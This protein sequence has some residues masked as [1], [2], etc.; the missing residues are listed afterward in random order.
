MGSVSLKVGDGTARFHRAT[1]CS[2]AVNILMI[3]SVITTNLFALY[4]FTA[5]PKHPHHS[6]LHHNAHKNISLISEQVSLILREIDLSQKKLAQMEKELLGYESIDL[7]RP[8]IASE[9]K[10]FLQRHQLPLGKDS[11]TGITEMVPSVGHTCEK[12]SDLL[13]QFMNYK[14]FGACPDDWSVAQKLILKGCEPLPRR[15]C[16]AKTVSKVGL[17]PFPDSLWKPV[18]NKTV[19]WSGLNCKNFECLNGKKL[20]RECVG[21]FDLVHGNENVR[22]VKAKSKNDFL[23]DDVLALGGGGVRIGL[24]IGGGSG[25]FAARM[26]DRNVTVVTST[27]NVEAP[28][29]EFIAARGLFPLY[30]S[31][32]HRFPFY[33]NVFDLVHASSGLDV[34]GKS[35]KLEFFMFDIDRVL[36]A[37]GLFWLDNFFCANE[38]KKQVLTRLIERFGYKKLKWVVGEKVDSVGSGKPE[39]VLSAVLQ[40]PVRA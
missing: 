7:S 6:L 33:D 32:D 38:E 36:R 35:E 14:V 28:F 27:L 9:L 39:V 37:G 10:L 8:N 26:A 34:G 1:L 23:V 22:F 20:S 12:N 19:N 40:K 30:L 31:L 15:R 2:S 18:G 24:D 5:S 21:C 3:F 29:S 11:R 4:A 17:Y 25:S 16:F 13:S